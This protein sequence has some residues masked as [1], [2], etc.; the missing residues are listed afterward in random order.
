MHSLK[1]ILYGATRNLFR[2]NRACTQG[3]SEQFLSI[4]C[5]SNFKVVSFLGYTFMSQVTNVTPLMSLQI[6]DWDQ[7][8][9][10]SCA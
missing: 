7:R 10:H 5:V 4:F 3:N 9:E 2:V 6:W 8:T 1:L